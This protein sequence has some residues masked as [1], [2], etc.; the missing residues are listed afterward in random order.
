MLFFSKISNK[1]FGFRLQILW[2]IAT[3][4]SIYFLYFS[5]KNANQPSQGFASY[6]TA[7]NLLIKGESVADFYNDDWFSSKV[8]KYVPGVYEI[9]LINMPTTALIF[10][11]IANFNYKTAKIIWT[12]FN[13][14]LLLLCLD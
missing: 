10:L 5:F 13:L 9:Y 3:A 12:I 6:Y 7:S 14:L 11:P 4:L 1:I 8:E 2:V